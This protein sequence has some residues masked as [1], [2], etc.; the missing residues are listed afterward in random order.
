MK[1]EFIPETDGGVFACE[2]RYGNA[3]WLVIGRPDSTS[4]T[5]ADAGNLSI[6]C[7]IEKINVFNLTVSVQKTIDGRKPRLKIIY[8][9][10]GKLS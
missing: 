4:Y 5:S 3:W 1:T 8:G 2:P 9:R 10:F 7:N 6:R